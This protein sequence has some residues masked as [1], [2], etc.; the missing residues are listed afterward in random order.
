[1]YIFKPFPH[2]GQNLA[3]FFTP[4]HITCPI[5]DWGNDHWYSFLSLE[6]ADVSTV[7]SPFDTG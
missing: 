7:Y 1:M 5:L 3:Y 6:N 2:P 4:A